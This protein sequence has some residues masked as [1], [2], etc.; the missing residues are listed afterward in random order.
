MAAGRSHV[1]DALSVE[2]VSTLCYGP[3]AGSLLGRLSTRHCAG[4]RE[5]HN[6][7]VPRKDT[8]RLLAAARAEL[9]G[10]AVP[11]PVG[12]FLCPLCLRLLPEPRATTGHYP[13]A[14]AGGGHYALQCEDC[15]SRL[16]QELE[17][18]AAAFLRSDEWELTAGPPGRGAIRIPIVLEDDDGPA[19]TIGGGKGSVRQWRTLRT[20]AERSSR[21]DILEWQIT[22]PHEDALR[23][24]I[25]AWT[26]AEWTRYA[27]YLWAA[28]EGAD[29]V[30]RVLL[31]GAVPIPT[32]AVIFPYEP[33]SESIG[34]PSPVVVVQSDGP[35]DLRSP[36]ME[37]L[38]VGVMWG[39]RIVGIMPAASDGAGSVYDKVVAHHE[40][41]RPIRYVDIRE[42]MRAAG[43][44]RMDKILR[45]RNTGR[46]EDVFVTK[47]LEAAEADAIARD[48]HP[49]RM[50]PTLG[51]KREFPPGLS[52]QFR[53]VEDLQF[54]RPVPEIDDQPRSS[55]SQMG[56]LERPVCVR[57]T[58]KNPWHV[59][60][61]VRGMREAPKDFVVLCGRDVSITGADY[62]PLDRPDLDGTDL[63]CSN[64]VRLAGVKPIAQRRAEGLLP[65]LAKD[66]WRRRI[67]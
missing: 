47:P 24:A 40:A 10:L 63:I 29:V 16:G 51:A 60:T 44:V 67:P 52:H 62:R 15:N 11:L 59:A 3:A 18:K 28:S 37:V 46:H 45:I 32:S 2:N 14:R 17:G 26:F 33:L 42:A 55:K 25:L 6:R 48:E 21:R 34:E 61:H 4:A 49:R 31:D 64:C 7:R 57:A 35:V 53:A 54:R 9:E 56:L 41:G 13:S 65:P 19:I 30:R 66:A 27:G 5:R 36:E 20:L 43:F 22:R 23:A 8:V 58:N 1:D 38:G 39:D 12:Q 50:D